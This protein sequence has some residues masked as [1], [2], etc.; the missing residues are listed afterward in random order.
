L[1]YRGL[2][3]EQT[4]KQPTNATASNNQNKRDHS[5]AGPQWPWL[6]SSPLFNGVAQPRDHLTHGHYW[7]GA[8]AGIA[9]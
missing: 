8:P 9:D 5:T 6:V 3:Q 1:W 2:G 4:L 7:M